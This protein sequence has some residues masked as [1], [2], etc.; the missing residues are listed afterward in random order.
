MPLTLE[1]YVEKIHARPDLPWPS[2]PKIDAPKAKPSLHPMP[3]RAVF[4]T[5]YGTLVAIP[6]GEIAFEH[7][8]EFLTAAALEKVI[9]EFKMW[10]SMSR[11]PGAPSEYMRELFNKALTTLRLAGS[12]GEK[13]PEVQSERVWD[14]IVKK[15]QQKDYSFDAVTYGSLGEYVQKI[16]YFYHASIQGVGP[17]PGAA[18][19]L[20]LLADRSVFQ[21][22]LADGQCFTFGQLQRCLRLEDPDV[23]LNAIIP[24]ALRLISAE[25]K[26]RKPSDTLFKAAMTLAEGRGLVP[27]EVLHIGSN[28]TRDIGPAKKYGFRTALFA[29]DKNSLSATGEQLKDP[30]LR[31][32]ALITELPQVL[33]LIE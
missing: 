30:A 3:V 25:K 6:Q 28:L 18:D 8:Q 33:E 16:A 29:G 26:A 9:K 23:D 10:N 32:D 11:K 21:G 20:K 2:A 19:A 13:F 4:W 7:P 24:P 5:V 31:P 22:L 14:D 1:Q 27:S 12:G 15:L 17:Y